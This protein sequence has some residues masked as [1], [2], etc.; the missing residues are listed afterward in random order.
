MISG[1]RSGG[2]SGKFANELVDTI[3]SSVVDILGWGDSKEL[4]LDTVV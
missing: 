2:S 4:L 3:V 1:E